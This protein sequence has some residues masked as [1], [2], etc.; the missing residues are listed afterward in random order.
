[1]TTAVLV[2]GIIYAVVTLLG[3]IAGLTVLGEPEPYRRAY[4]AHLVLTCWA[5]PWELLQWFP[6]MWREIRELDDVHHGRG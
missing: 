2:V 6:A 4:G 3:F 5:W 1:M